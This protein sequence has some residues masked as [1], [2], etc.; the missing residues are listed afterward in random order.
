MNL[1]IELPQQA[2]NLVLRV[3]PGV[4]APA[5]APGAEEYDSWTAGVAEYDSW[6]RSLP[7]TPRRAAD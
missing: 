2:D 5:T 6:S 1:T 4:P 3:V 7:G